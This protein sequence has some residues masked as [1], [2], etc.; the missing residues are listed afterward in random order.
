MV[1]PLI[2]LT[3]YEFYEEY[4]FAGV[5]GVG[6]TAYPTRG[7]LPGQYFFPDGDTPGSGLID[8]KDSFNAFNAEHPGFFAKVEFLESH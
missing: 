1:K 5:P 8:A 7:L 6:V 2:P 3:M 4:L